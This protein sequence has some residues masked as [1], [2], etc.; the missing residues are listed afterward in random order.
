[1]NWY[2]VTLMPIFRLKCFQKHLVGYCLAV[3][4]E[5]LWPG[6]HIEQSSLNQAPPTGRSNLDLSSRSVIDSCPAT[7]QLQLGSDWLFFWNL[8]NAI[9]ST[10][11]GRETWYFS[12]DYLSHVLLSGYSGCFIKITFFIIFA[13][14]N[15]LQLYRK[16]MKNWQL[17]YKMGN[18]R[19]NSKHWSRGPSAPPV[20]LIAAHVF[21]IWGLPSKHNR[22]SLC[23]AVM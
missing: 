18:S 23:P 11:G 8:A 17:T 13:Q 4:W 9:W 15:Q 12:T 20:W 10:G 19:P 5:S 7:A 22:V 16:N 14:S 2:S 3:K 6:S 21:A 1:M